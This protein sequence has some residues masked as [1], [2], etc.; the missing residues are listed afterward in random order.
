MRVALG[1]DIHR[2]EKA[3]RPLIIGGV[4]IER[5][6]SVIAHS[7]GDALAHALID[8]IA[9]LFLS[10][11]IGEIF[12]DSNDK[13]KG[14]NSLNNLKAVYEKAGRP[15]ITNIDAVIQTDEIMITPYAEKIQQN[16]EKT[17]NLP[18]HTVTIKGKRAEGVYNTPLIQVWA[19]VLFS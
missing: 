5:P 6:Y 7:D 18:P 9:P 15:A 16:V 3:T 12:S 4:E 17:L 8:A 13:N 2:L 10:K 14:A 11:N 19:V 1:Y